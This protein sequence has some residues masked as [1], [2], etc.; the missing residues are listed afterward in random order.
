MNR[1]PSTKNEE[2]KKDF[3]V[4]EEKGAVQLRSCIYFL[5]EAP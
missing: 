1:S 2:K 5:K 3:A 4:R